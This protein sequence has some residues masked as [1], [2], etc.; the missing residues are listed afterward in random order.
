MHTVTFDTNTGQIDCF[1]FQ[2]FEITTLDRLIP[3]CQ[4]F[5]RT[6]GFVNTLD[7][8]SI[9]SLIVTATRCTYVEIRKERI[10]V[11]LASDPVGL[12]GVGG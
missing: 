6:R 2:H 11:L 4:M 9:P 7:G 1:Q 8:S 3:D 10:N 5:C 12:V